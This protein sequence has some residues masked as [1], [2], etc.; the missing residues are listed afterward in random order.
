MFYDIILLGYGRVIMKNSLKYIL[1][2]IVFV[3][4]V[5]SITMSIL[6]TK[7][8]EQ[9]NFSLSRKKFEVLFTNV[10]V[11][12]DN[13]KVKLDN[14]NKSIHIE[15]NNLTDTEEVSLDIKNTANID[16]LLKNYSISNI[17]TNAKEGSI[18]VY[19]STKNGE[20]IK[21]GETKKLIVIIKNNSKDKNIYYNFNINYLFEEYN[22]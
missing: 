10:L 13:I 22:L 21:K 17:N 18:I 12:N 19:V 9:G 2:I 3:V 7:Y 20:V 4:F 6:F 15:T 5:V 14:Q 11:N 1:L 16:A 8:K